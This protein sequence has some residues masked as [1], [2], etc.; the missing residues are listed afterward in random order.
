MITYD[1]AYEKARELKPDFDACD[2]YDKGYMFKC[3]AD[4][5]S[6]GGSGPCVIV[7]ETGEAISD[8]VFYDEYAPKFIK[9][10]EV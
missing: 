8:L 2:E 4:K 1:E 3:K 6:I 10:V 9:E 5:F 7:K